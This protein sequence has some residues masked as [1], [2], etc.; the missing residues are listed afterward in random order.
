MDDAAYFDTLTRIEHARCADHRATGYGGVFG[1][2]CTDCVA[3]QDA[4]LAY[5]R[6]QPLEFEPA[7]PEAWR[8][9]VARLRA[10]AEAQRDRKAARATTV[11][12]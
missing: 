6:D 8:D 4:A 11:A 1:T 2:V 5:W 12:A 9:A 3:T 7:D 10:M